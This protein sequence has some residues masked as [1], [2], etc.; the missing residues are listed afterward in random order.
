MSLADKNLK[1]YNGV[2]VITK[3]EAKTKD[4]KYF[5]VTRERGI[6]KIKESE[7]FYMFHNFELDSSYGW[8]TIKVTKV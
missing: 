7:D 4:F 8:N 2:K 6:N 3:S 1:S 5:S